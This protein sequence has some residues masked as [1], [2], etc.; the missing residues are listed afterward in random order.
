MPTRWISSAGRWSAI[1]LTALGMGAATPAPVVA[2]GEGARW[3]MEEPPGATVMV[4]S[5]GHG[6]HGTIPPEVRAGGGKLAFPGMASVL[7]PHSTGLNPGSADFS[8]A[9]RVRRTG[10]YADPNLIQKGQADAPNGYYK[11]D[12]YKGQVVCTLKGSAATAI[13]GLPASIS[14]KFFHTIRCSK[15]ATGMRLDVDPGTARARSGTK[16]ITIG[17]IANVK[18]L[19]LGG[20]T[21]CSDVEACDWFTGQMAWARVD[22]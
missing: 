20:K 2:A 12:Y 11:I 14:D 4:D 5:S 18:P 19:T 21:N 3:Q 9:V 16:L 22:F 13:I 1:A 8:F 17:S 15:T 10:G 6:H 7:V